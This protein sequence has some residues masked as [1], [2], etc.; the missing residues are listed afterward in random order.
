MSTL[1]AATDR[2]AF[3]KAAVGAAAAFAAAAG[4]TASA[5]DTVMR[6]AAGATLGSHMR[7]SLAA[8]GLR[9]LLPVNATADELAK[10]SM[11]LSGFLDYCA[12]LNLDGSELTGYYFPKIVQETPL[13]RTPDGPA[14]AGLPA[15]R[16][17][18]LEYLLGLRNQAFRQGLTISGTAIGNDFC[19]PEGPGWV[20]QV[21]LCKDWIDIAAAVGAPVIRI[22]AGKVPAGDSEAM[23]LTRCVTAIDE[24]L[25]YAARRGVFLALENHG[26]LTADPATMLRLIAAVKPSPWFGVNLDTANF[27]TDDPYRDLAKIAPYALNVQIKASVLPGGT[28]EPADLPRLVGILKDAGYRGFLVLEYEEPEDPKIAIPPLVDRLRELIAV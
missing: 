2:R 5:A 24:C 16:D 17:A 21:N 22:F 3:L 4:G 19:V 10:A 28:K 23:A 6:A 18:A 27:K 7:L 14:D 11:T 12:A 8:Y 20:A 9:T 13:R 15:K 26:G 1:S 25:T